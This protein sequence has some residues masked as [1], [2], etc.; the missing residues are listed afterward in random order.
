MTPERLDEALAFII[1]TLREDYSAT[2]ARMSDYESGLRH[3]SQRRS[4]LNHAL[5]MAETAR[6]FAASGRLEKAFRWFGFVEGVLWK[7]GALS[8]RDLREMG[9]KRPGG[10]PIFKCGDI[11]AL[12]SDKLIQRRITQVRPSGYSLLQTIGDDAYE[13]RTE[14][15]DDQ[16][17]IEWELVEV[18]EVAHGSEEVQPEQVAEA[19]SAGQEEGGQAPPSSQEAHQEG[20]SAG[21]VSS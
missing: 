5:W 7:E 1:K 17:L 18:V 9:R 4:S 14:S 13:N 10:V 3:F 11:V 2:P 15:T 19:E 16:F 6:N 12:K 21:D 8:I 20:L